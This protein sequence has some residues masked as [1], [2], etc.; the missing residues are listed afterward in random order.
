MTYR[1]LCTAYADWKAN[2]GV[3]R[4][5]QVLV[6]KGMMRPDVVGDLYYSHANEDVF[7]FAKMHCEEF[8]YLQ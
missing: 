7:K 6:N 5:A 8:M 2:P 1:E 4:F 3:I